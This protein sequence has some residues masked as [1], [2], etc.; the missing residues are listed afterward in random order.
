[1]KARLF[2][3]P[4]LAARILNIDDQFGLE[5][6]QRYLGG[7][8]RGAGRLWLTTR[9]KPERWFE[10]ANYVC[11]PGVSAT[12][13]GLT[14]SLQ[15]SVGEAR[16]VSALRGSFNADNLLTVLALLLSRA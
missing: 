15:T 11:A 16:L 6:A 12:R 4:A 7:A 5:L 14:L 1:A 10:N 2:E 13:E 3:W 8:G 9:R